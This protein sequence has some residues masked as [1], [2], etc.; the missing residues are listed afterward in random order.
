MSVG[1]D[2]DEV[3]QRA[4]DPQD[5]AG[6][7]VGDNEIADGVEN[8]DPVPVGLV[9]ARKQ[10]GIFEGHRGVSGDGLKDLRIFVGRKRFAISQIQDAYQFSRRTQQPHQRGVG[11]AEFR[12]ERRTE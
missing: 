3:G 2:P 9:H 11:G 8:L 12:G 6:F 7:V 10:A 4:V 1:L 5:I